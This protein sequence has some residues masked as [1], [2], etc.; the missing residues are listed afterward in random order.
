VRRHFRHRRKW[1]GDPV[2][3]RR[4]VYT[5]D[6]H[7]ARHHPVGHDQRMTTNT[8]QLYVVPVTRHP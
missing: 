3:D 7:L 5:V 6:T 1:I 8:A 4:A 2:T